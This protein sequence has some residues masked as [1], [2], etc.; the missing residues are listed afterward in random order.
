MK[1]KRLM[2]IG[3]ISLLITAGTGIAFGSVIEATDA[4]KTTQI[5]K[6][7]IV[8]G[9][10]RIQTPR[11]TA[12]LKSQSP[13]VGSVDWVSQ[14]KAEKEKIRLEAEQ[15]QIELEAEID[16]LEA[17][18]EAEVNRQNQI[19]ENT[20]K[21]N[22]AIELVKAQIGIT[23]WVHGGSSLRAWDCS[24][25]VRWAYAHVGIDMRHSANAQRNF[26]TIVTEPKFGDLVSFSRIGGSASHIG[27]YLSP[28]E[29]IHSG[30]RPGQKTAIRSISNFAQ[31]NGTTEVVYTRIIETNN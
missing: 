26:G 29:M 13:E 8:S 24:G 2:T 25:L 21:L 15:K 1:R 7:I 9:P 11:I 30:G 20:E 14:E 17:E 3:L 16:R 12:V 31:G 28:D 4:I 18:L 5:K 22:E 6:E 27:I 19:K 10:V 23:P